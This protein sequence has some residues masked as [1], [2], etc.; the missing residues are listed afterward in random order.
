MVGVGSPDPG[1]RVGGD[2]GGGKGKGEGRF[3]WTKFT[4]PVSHRTSGSF[5]CPP[6]A[7]T[8][9][10]IKPQPPQPPPPTD[11]EFVTPLP[12]GLADSPTPVCL[13]VCLPRLKFGLAQVCTASV[14]LE[15]AGGELSWPGQAR[16]SVCG[17]APRRCR[18]PKEQPGQPARPA[19]PASQP[20]EPEPARA[21]PI[22]IRWSLKRKTLEVAD[23]SHA[24][25]KKRSIF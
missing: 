3:R 21:A 10:R 4:F 25:W 15:R 23:A 2:S 7:V 13:S 9:G 12:L 8:P 20:A 6:S 18:P 14:H 1:R 5:Q 17:A 19:R 22:A 24:A 11:S 16:P